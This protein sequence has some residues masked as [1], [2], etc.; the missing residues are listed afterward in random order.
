MERRKRRAGIADGAGREGAA[1]VRCAADLREAQKTIAR[2]EGTSSP[3]LGVVAGGGGDRA[4]ATRRR[5][6]SK[7]PSLCFST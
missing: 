7:M 2:H 6:Q 1:L 4:G 5:D 3:D